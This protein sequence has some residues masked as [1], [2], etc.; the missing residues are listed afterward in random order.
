[1]VFTVIHR[2]ERSSREVAPRRREETHMLKKN[3]IREALE[4]NRAKLAR[5]CETQH[6]RWRK[7]SSNAKSRRFLPIIAH[8]HPKA[9]AY[10]F[11]YLVTVQ[12]Q[13][14]EEKAKQDILMTPNQLRHLLVKATTIE[15]GVLK[16]I[17]E[18]R[19]ETY[20]KF[21]YLCKHP[22]FAFVYKNASLG[23]Q[24]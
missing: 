24:K 13:C 5:K 6:A 7:D 19:Q 20:R 11:W 4:K 15:R 22:E 17:F 18:K 12:H 16:A 23:P 1:M 21:L 14:T 9:Q 2:L 3:S 10:S 8:W